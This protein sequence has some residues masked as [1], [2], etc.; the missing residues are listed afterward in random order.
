MK[1]NL[2]GLGQ[3]GS[4][5]VYDVIA[6]LFKQKTSKEIRGD[7][8]SRWMHDFNQRLAQLNSRGGEWKISF[9]KYFS[10][11]G[12]PD[13]P[14]FFVIDGN[15]KNAILD[16]LQGQKLNKI[17]PLQILAKPLIVSNRDNGCT[18][19]Q[20]GEQVFRNEIKLTTNS[21]VF[22]QLK[23][24]NQIE[25]NA[26]VFAGGGGSGSGGAPVLNEV[27]SNKDS[28]LFNMMVLPPYRISDRRQ[29][30]NTGRCIMRLASTGKQTALLL[31]SNLSEDSD[32]QTNLNLY[33]GRL[34]L[35]LANFGYPGNVAKVATDLDRKDL[36]TFFAGKPAFV[37]MSSL[38]KEKPSEGEIEEMVK[39][40][41]A[42]RGK[43]DNEGLSIVLPKTLQKEQLRQIKM[44]MVVLGLPPQYAR[45]ASIVD[46]VKQKVMEHLETKLENLDCRAYSY[47][48]PKEIELT[49]FLRHSNYKSNFLLYHFLH[50]YLKWHSS[51]ETEYQYITKNTNDQLGKDFLDG[52]K[53]AVT[54]EADNNSPNWLKE[55]FSRY[56]IYK[57]EEFEKIEEIK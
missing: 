10:K 34:I 11:L 26:L 51:K 21:N 57:I 1:I 41:L 56:R 6:V 5:V 22:N 50:Q 18:L 8:Q 55:N 13:I 27:L 32:D 9:K 3:C 29:T 33:I 15:R 46:T 4:F 43:Q 45:D 54:A 49:I 35:R 39:R 20:I 42:H 40:A 16:G 47:T 31:F 19:G 25:I 38:N 12:Y 48:S 14:Q 53:K 37:G 44:V 7:I 17:A 24:N 52:V 23:N 30:W 36:Q 2:I 28:L